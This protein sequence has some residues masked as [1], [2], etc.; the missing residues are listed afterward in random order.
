MLSTVVWCAMVYVLYGMWGY[1]CRHGFA[2]TMEHKRLLVEALGILSSRINTFSTS[3]M[4]VRELTKYVKHL[5]Y[6]H[7]EEVILNLLV[8]IYL[9]LP[10]ICIKSQGGILLFGKVCQ[11]NSQHFGGR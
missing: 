7:C 5:L 10:C 4:A 11:D 1:Y 3:Q 6:V 9:A 2:G 8:V